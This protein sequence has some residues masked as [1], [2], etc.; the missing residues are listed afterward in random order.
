M[1]KIYLRIVRSDGK[2]FLAD[3]RLSDDADW[4]ITAI[5]GIGAAS[6]ENF[7]ENKAVG[8]G[9]IITGSRIKS[10]DIEFTALAKNVHMNSVL[11]LSAVSFF[12]PKYTYQ[13]Y[14][15]Y[16]GVTRWIDAVLEAV[17]IPSDNKRNQQK[18]TVD[19]FCPDPCFKSVDAFGADIAAVEPMWTFEEIDD[20]DFGEPFDSFNFAKNVDITNDGDVETYCKVVI[21][22][23]GNVTNPKFIHGDAYIRIIDEMQSGDVIE[24]DIANRTVYKNGNNI[25]VKIDRSSNFVDMAFSVG[26]NVV[27]YDADIGETAMSVT[28]FYNK[29]YLGV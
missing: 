4:G 16:N 10:R 12:N 21:R 18:I 17:D 7:T 14:V 29:L 23:K 28:L 15:T 22:A 8:D 3:G 2:E 9:D 6:F 20:P 25:L 13:V 5:S 27:A 24:I 1:S 19:F 26:D 11:R